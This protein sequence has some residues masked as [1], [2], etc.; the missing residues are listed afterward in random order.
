MRAVDEGFGQVHLAALP[1]ILGERGK[2]SVE[3]ALTLPLLEPVV[4]R[5]RRRVASRKVG[6]RRARPQHPEDPVEQIAWV[7]PRTPAALARA[8]PLRLRDAAADRFPLLVGEVHRRRY[9]HLPSP[10]ERAS[11]KMEQSRSLL[12]RPVVGC[13][14][15][16]AV[17][18]LTPARPSLGTAVTTL[19][20]A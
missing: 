4:A 6:P 5:L 11:S 2:H 14:L 8:L 19:T 17:S 20:A 10:M 12:H 18:T 1:K 16:A 13:A 15:G 7:P 3:H 9:K